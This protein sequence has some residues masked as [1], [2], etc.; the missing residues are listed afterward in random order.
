MTSR[1][2]GSSFAW[3]S[4]TTCSQSSVLGVRTHAFGDRPPVLHEGGTPHEEPKMAGVDQLARNMLDWSRYQIGQCPHLFGW[5][6]VILVPAS[7]KIGQLIADKSTVVPSTTSTPRKFVL[8]EQVLDDPEVEGTWKVLRPFEPIG[9]VDMP[10]DVVGIVDI[11]EQ[12][13]QAL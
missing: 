9:E 12:A 1:S 7:R 2:S 13:H 6:D 8:N 10:G 11:R 3:P 4:R 5:R